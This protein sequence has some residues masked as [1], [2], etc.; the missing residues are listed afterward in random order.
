MDTQVAAILSALVMV[1]A[2]ANAQDATPDTPPKAV[3]GAKFVEESSRTLIGENRLAWIEAMRNKL[4]ITQ[5]QVGPFGLAQDPEAALAKPAQKKMK[6]GAFLNAIAA[7]KVNTVMPSESKFTI[8]SRE[9]SKGDV[10]PVIRGQRQF[11]VEI[12]AIRADNILFK[13]IDTGEYVKRNLHTLPKGMTKNAP[14]DSVP[15]VVPANKKD[16]RPLNLDDEPLPVS[17]D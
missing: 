10:F 11:N 2:V 15:G 9:F 17:N 14:L 8:G 4:P 5:R 3:A 6:E 1:M 7:I 12:V 13:N 16:D